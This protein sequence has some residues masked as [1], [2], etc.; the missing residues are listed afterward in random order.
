MHF[1]INLTLIAVLVIV[2]FFNIPFYNNW[3]NTNILNPSIS[4]FA[5]LD[6]ETEARKTSRYGYS[7]LIY[8]ELAEVVKKVVTDS[9]VVLLPPEQFIKERGITNTVIPEPA[10]FY[11]FTSQKAVWYNSPGVNKANCALVPDNGRLILR[12][13]ETPADLE[14]LISS[15][16]KYKI[17]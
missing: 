6:T 10:V 1:K 4:M 15:Y 12:K 16:K 11:Y 2:L 13:I 5:G 9:P 7:Y 14:N 3:L 8:K 17:D